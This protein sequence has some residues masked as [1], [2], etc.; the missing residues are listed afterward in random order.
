[1]EKVYEILDKMS[2]DDVTV[3]WNAICSGGLKNDSLINGIPTEEWIELVY[4]E[5]IRRSLST[6]CPLFWAT[7]SD[8]M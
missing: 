7:W 8:S 4:I 3:C 1:M 6:R 5:M 2:N